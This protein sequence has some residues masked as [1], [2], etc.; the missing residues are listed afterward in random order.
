[1]LELPKQWCEY[2]GERLLHPNLSAALLFPPFFSSSSFPGACCSH[3]VS[4]SAGQAGHCATEGLSIPLWEEFGNSLFL[5]ATL[6]CQWLKQ[7]LFRMGV[8]FV[9]FFFSVFA[10]FKLEVNLRKIKKEMWDNLVMC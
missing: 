10:V 6:C 2:D 4:C 5:T 3:I 9:F 1:M 7:T 8:F